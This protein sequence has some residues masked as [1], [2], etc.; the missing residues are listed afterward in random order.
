MLWNMVFI[1]LPMTASALTMAM[2]MIVTIN[3]Y[4]MAVE[5]RRSRAKPPTKDRGAS[6]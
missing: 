2:E 4:S 5:A 3:A 6:G 1:S